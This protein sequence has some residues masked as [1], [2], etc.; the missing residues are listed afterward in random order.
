MLDHCKTLKLIKM[1][2]SHLTDLEIKALLIQYDSE[3]R[4]L[5]FQMQM[6]HS[7]LQNLH[8]KLGENIATIR[9]ENKNGTVSSSNILK[10]TNGQLEFNSQTKEEFKTFKKRGR[11]PNSKLHQDNLDLTQKTTKKRGRKPKIQDN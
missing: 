4:K 2:I 8:E 6:I 1:D 9:L 5:S 7:T 11:K 3:L 10:A